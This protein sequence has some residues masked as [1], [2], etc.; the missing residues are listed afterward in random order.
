MELNFAKTAPGVM[1][2]SWT[3]P[4]KGRQVSIAIIESCDTQHLFIDGE[5]IARD[6][7]T[8]DDAV[9]LAKQRVNA[10]QAP[11]LVRIAGAFVAASL[12]GA[13]V[14][15][16]AKFM[17]AISTAEIV[18]AASPG[19]L[20]ENHNTKPVQTEPHAIEAPAIPVET[21][22]LTKPAGAPQAPAAPPAQKAPEPV[23]QATV[24]VTAPAARPDSESDNPT[25]VRRRFSARKN[26]LALEAHLAEQRAAARHEKAAPEPAEAVSIEVSPTPEM[27]PVEPAKSTPTLALAPAAPP[28]PAIAPVSARAPQ[29][30]KAPIT[31]PQVQQAQ[32]AYLE[33]SSKPLIRPMIPQTRDDGDIESA[34][35]ATA[36][37]GPP[38]PAKAPAEVQSL[39]KLANQEAESTEPTTTRTTTVTTPRKASPKPSRTARPAR[40]THRKA[41]R[42]PKR[43]RRAAS[44][45]VRTAGPGKRLVCF[46]H[47][48]RWR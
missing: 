46:A 12:I 3:H 36:P 2:A 11:G 35:P 24:E 7:P 6:L 27:A 42:L 31:P 33:A 13:S 5:L 38:L 30:S 1:S 19:T 44:H 48:C 8:F 26:L 23:K 18:A 45:R 17:P 9:T 20:T 10:T 37:A 39:G 32:T 40:K 34:E 41:R 25:E 47:I 16:A 14:F 28:A 43:T 22:S 21:E 15:V 29:T 4:K